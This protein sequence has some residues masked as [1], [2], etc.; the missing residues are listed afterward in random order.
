MPPCESEAMVQRAIVLVGAVVGALV[1]LFAF[2][3]VAMRTRSPRMLRVVR[4]FNRAVTNRMQL[5]TAGR[6]GAGA[7]VIR[8][9][10]RR[11]GKDYET[12]IGAFEIDDGYIVT[13]PYGSGADWVQN[14]LA[15]GSAVLVHEGRT[16]PVDRPEL[17]RVAEAR[18]WYPP[19]EQ[20]LHRLFGVEHGLRLHDAGAPAGSA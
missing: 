3:V 8:H 17:I 14:V 2:V 7:S 1:S 20:R 12:P 13:L 6:P 5:R 11:S 9:V 4:R 10:G 15:A 18:E 19:S 16:L